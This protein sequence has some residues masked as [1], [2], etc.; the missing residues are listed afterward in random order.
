[1]YKVLVVD[2]EPRQVK[3]MSNIIKQL[4]PEYEVFVAMD[5]QEAL[6]LLQS[7]SIDILITDIRMPGM[8]GLQL[9]E[10]ISELKS[11][12][13]IKVIILSG[14]EEFEYAQKAMHFGT[15]DYLVKPIGKAEIESVLSRLEGKIKSEH[16]EIIQKES[17]LKKLDYS[18]P[19]YLEHQL[20]KWVRNELNE[21]EI[22]EIESIFSYKGAGTVIITVL[23][24]LKH[25]TGIENNSETNDMKQYL[26]Y[27]MKQLLN[28]IGHSISFFMEGEKG[29]MATILN[30]NKE[31]NLLS[32]D[33]I[34]KFE[35]FIY[36]IKT[37]YGADITIGLGKK[38]ANIFDDVA[39]CFQ[40]AKI[41]ED[42]KFYFGL[43]RVI[44]Y[45]NLKVNFDNRTLNL[46]S[47]EV[48]I[49]D[50]VRRADIG[51][52]HGIVR[53]IFESVNI[54][55]DIQP[56]QFKEG[57]AD[58]ILSQVKIIQD[59]VIEDYYQNFIFEIK[60]ELIACEEFNE[61]RHIANE[62]FAKI[63]SILD[64]NESDKNGIIIKKCKKYIEEHYAENLSLEFIANK[65]YFNP[66]YFSNLFKSYS[67]IVF[68]EYLIKIRMQ[69]AQQLL[70]NTD[71]TMYDIAH[72][73][74]FKDAAYFNRLF[75]REF[76]ISPNKY[77]QTTCNS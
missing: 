45:S 62:A 55:Q 41:S 35:E 44:A 9:I 2:D 1:M 77:R 39:Q 13:N 12:N 66:S 31:F 16:E 71:N 24:K 22:S 52:L 53:E 32:N 47:K 74:G 29:V 51:R 48:E 60:N 20:N 30:T 69:K 3:A 46:H 67:G 17:I 34:K 54:Y 25:L 28:S 33:N 43:R 75:K 38:S 5:G 58:I 57:I 50:A 42:Y 7:A 37:E 40:Q 14:Y 70:K 10:K 19:V 64:E 61:C 6:D 4:R 73:V 36:N 56:R 72:M 59:L 18:L 65:F 23:S 49:V 68:S 21:S 63:I 11:L 26:K 8:D 15:F 27:S 76:G